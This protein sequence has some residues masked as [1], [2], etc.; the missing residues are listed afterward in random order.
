MFLTLAD[1]FLIVLQGIY[2]MNIQEYTFLAR[3]DGSS[4]HERVSAYIPILTGVY[5]YDQYS[6]DLPQTSKLC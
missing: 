3:Y 2:L 1:P 6:T 4:L 5:L